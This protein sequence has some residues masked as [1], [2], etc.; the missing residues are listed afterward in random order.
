MADQPV[1]TRVLARGRW[2]PFQEFMIREGAAGPV[3]GVELRGIEAA[4]P[5]PEVLDAIAEAEAIVI[6]PSYPVISI[7]PILAVP[8][9]REARFLR[10]G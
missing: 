9:I 5:T 3:E 4:R 8:G 10:L 6:G 2:V 1:R 7:G